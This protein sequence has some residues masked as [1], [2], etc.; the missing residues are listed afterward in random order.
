[1]KFGGLLISYG[2]II[3]KKVQVDQV[4]EFFESTIMAI[5]CETGTPKP[6]MQK[7]R[8]LHISLRNLKN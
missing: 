2:G 1:M 4:L 3:M 6:A 7:Y 8:M 5:G